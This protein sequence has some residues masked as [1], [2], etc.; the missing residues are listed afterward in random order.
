MSL[1]YKVLAFHLPYID[2]PLIYDFSF[3]VFLLNLFWYMMWNKDINYCPLL[4]TLNIFN[5]YL[6]GKPS[7]ADDC[8]IFLFYVLNPYACNY[9]YVSEA[10]LRSYLSFWIFLCIWL[11]NVLCPFSMFQNSWNV[12]MCFKCI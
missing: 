10:S 8:G 6:L 9:T 3:Y 2:F 1:R 5:S 12:S 11:F 4:K 7:L